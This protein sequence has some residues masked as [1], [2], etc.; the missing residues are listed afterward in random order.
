MNNFFKWKGTSLKI[1]S[2]SEK[3]IYLINALKCENINLR[4][5][6]SIQILENEKLYFIFEE[7]FVYD[8]KNLNII[9][10]KFAYKSYVD[11]SKFYNRKYREFNTIKI[12]ATDK[13]IYEEIIK[14]NMID[15]STREFPISINVLNEVF[16]ESNDKTNL[17][18]DILILLAL[19]TKSY[20]DAEES[21]FEFKI[22]GNIYK[23][24]LNLESKPLGLFP[25]Y[26][27]I[28]NEEEYKESYGVKLQVVRQV[29]INK[30]SLNDISSILQDSKLAYKRIISKK[31]NEYFEQLNQL[32]D[33]FL[34]L[35]EKKNS[36]LRTLN[37]TF[38]AWLGSLWWELSDIIVKYEGND[39]FNYLMC[40]KGPKKSLIVLIFI[41]ALIA[42]FIGYVIEIKSLE[43]TYNTI[44]I[45]Y[46]DK[47]LFDTDNSE[48]NKFED[49]IHKP[50]VGKPQII[51]FFIILFILFVRFICTFSW[52]LC[53]LFTIFN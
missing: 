39:I 53:D 24:E 17:I 31:T 18:I 33:D 6:E 2:S 12:N 16:D 9:F 14:D 45:I 15:A 46:K 8:S 50:K 34:T 28:I 3:G 52:K 20:F 44:K 26:D 10:E 30:Q 32:K 11:T 40:S 7:E 41:A 21:K 48:K 36:S 43:E 4:D 49:I 29:I 42:I 47:I 23:T 13:D 19:A 38:F 51:I 25:L 1:D 5:K 27:W 22:D 37:L 35:S